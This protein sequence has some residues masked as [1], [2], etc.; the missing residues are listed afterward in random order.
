MTAVELQQEVT[1]LEERIRTKEDESKEFLQKSRDADAQRQEAKAALAS[2][3]QRVNE[4]RQTQ[5]IESAAESAQKALAV[6]ESAKT[7]AQAV[8]AALKGR[9]AELAEKSKR[10]DELLAKAAG[11]GESGSKAE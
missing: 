7:E 5:A 9:E 8:L 11:G 6:A 10:L 3:R 4:A 2:L 1:I